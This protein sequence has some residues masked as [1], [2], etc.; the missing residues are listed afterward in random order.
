MPLLLD[1][2]RPVINE[3]GAGREPVGL[4]PKVSSIPAVALS[5]FLLQPMGSICM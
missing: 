5:T 2:E 3:Q 1:G 4:T